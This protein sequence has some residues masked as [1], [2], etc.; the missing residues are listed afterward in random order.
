[1][2]SLTHCSVLAMTL[3]ALPAL[4]SG[5]GDGCGF[6]LTDC[7]LPTYP[8][9]LNENDTR[10][11][12]LMLL[13]DAQHHPLPFTLPADPL[14]ERSQPLF[15]LTRLPQPEEV[16]DPALREQLGSRLAAYDPSLPPLLEHYAGHDSLYG[17]AISNSLSSVSAFL[18]ALEQSG[19]PAPERTSLLRSRLLILGQQE[20]PAPATEMSDAAL[21]WQRYL[22]SARHFY[23]SRFEE[24]RAGFAALQQAKAPWVAE[25]ATYMVMRTEINLAMKEAKDEYGDQ[26]VTRSDKEA[27]RRAMAQ[28]QAYLV[29]YPQGRYASSTRGLF[30][31]IQ[32]M[33]GDL[34][35]LRDAYDEAMAT[36]QPLP[37][38][39]A[40][41]NEIDLTL[42]SGDAY[43]HQ[44]AYQ[45]SAQPALLFVN[46]LRGLRPTY[47]RPRPTV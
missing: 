44:A 41:V 29:A 15:Y 12:L 23:E 35:A 8:L 32:W 33:S 21:E 4:A 43:R 45:D 16:E 10:G 19:V 28:G 31:R 7:P 27:L 5:D 39:E 30:R 26:D 37:A 1:M 17:H 14:N 22:Q 24:A 6:W 20:S 46:A 25:S 42:L 47:E 13:G 9:Y 40:L 36:R 34:G 11:N 18:D 38:L 2:T 3:V